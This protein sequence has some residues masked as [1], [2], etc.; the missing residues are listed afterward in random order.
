MLGLFNDTD[1]R[2]RDYEIHGGTP[3]ILVKESRDPSVSSQR[4]ISILISTCTLTS[5]V[6]FYALNTAGMSTTTTGQ[7]SSTC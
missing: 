4:H 6:V 7:E 3:P 2:R 5:F 1:T